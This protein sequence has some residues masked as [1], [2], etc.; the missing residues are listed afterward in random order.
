MVPLSHPM[1][2]AAL[3]VFRRVWGL[4]GG[5]SEESIQDVSYSTVEELRSGSSQLTFMMHLDTRE[6]PNISEQTAAVL[7]FAE[8][9]NDMS[10]FRH[11]LSG[12]TG[13]PFLIQHLAAIAAGAIGAPYSHMAVW[14]TCEALSHS[15]VFRCYILVLVQ[16]E[17]VCHTF[18][19]LLG[20]ALPDKAI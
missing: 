15:S 1:W 20:Y 5:L 19:K 7:F 13:I 4:D 11:Y 6:D 16:I 10:R 2:Q 17:D 12:N 18:V 9:A 3:R 14:S 8:Y